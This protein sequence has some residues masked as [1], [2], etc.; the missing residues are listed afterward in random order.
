MNQNINSQP[1][2]AL[3]SSRANTL[4]DEKLDK[5]NLISSSLSGA[6]NFFQKPILDKKQYKPV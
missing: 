1:I 2:S 5:T 4:Q 6:S 3:P